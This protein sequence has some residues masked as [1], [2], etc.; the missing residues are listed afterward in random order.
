MHIDWW[1]LALQTVNVVIL[2]W[3]LGHFL[4]RPIADIMAR[5]QE[6]AGK[7]LAEA[8][9]ARSQAD[10]TRAESERVRAR[11]AASQER[12]MLDA[13]RTAQ[14][15]YAAALARAAAE[16]A[17]L[18]ADA[19]AAIARD[20]QL[21]EQALIA[22]ASDLAIKIAQRLLGR[23]P[24]ASAWNFFLDELCEQIR[25][26]SP[27][28]RA[29]FA[30]ANAGVNPVEMVTAAPL[31]ADARDRACQQVEAAFNAKLALGVRV[32]P[33]LIAGVELHSGHAVLRSSWQNDL[34]TIRKA[35]GRHD[36]HS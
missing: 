10:Q 3:L 16:S 13:Q 27:D 15:E 23:L 24:A 34:D 22:R 4:F 26:L 29:A 6:Q 14:A 7:L 17:K 33:A 18:R 9:A 30:P 8:A 20:R 11:L 36:E 25:G 2:I 5:R 28:L 32:D 19:E 35:L 31:A 21:A 12:Q 1:T